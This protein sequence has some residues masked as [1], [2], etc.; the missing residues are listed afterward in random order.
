MDTGNYDGLDIADYT[1][2]GYRP[3]VDFNCWR[4]AVLNYIDE[5]LPENIHRMERHVETDEVFILVQ[6]T[7]ILILGGSGDTVTRLETWPMDL[8]KIY[9]VKQNV[10][11]VALLSRDAKIILVENRDTGQANTEYVELKPE[12][13]EIVQDVAKWDMPP[14]DN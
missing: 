10:W 8:N 12:Q 5:L 7:A 1:E 14:F 3:L 13:M 4:V 6:G 11:H 2:E 9:N